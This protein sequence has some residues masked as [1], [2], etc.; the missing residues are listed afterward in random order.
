[1]IQ[2]LGAGPSKRIA[3]PSETN[4]EETA[5]MAEEEMSASVNFDGS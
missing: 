5:T 4:R 1:M 2:I 3:R